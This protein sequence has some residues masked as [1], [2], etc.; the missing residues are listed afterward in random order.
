[1]D[2]PAFGYTLVFK[3]IIQQSALRS[4][5]DAPARRYHLVVMKA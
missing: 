4:T 1:M 3:E 2:T 5:I